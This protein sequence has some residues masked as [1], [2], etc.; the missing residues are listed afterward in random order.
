MSTLLRYLNTE[1]QRNLY[2]NVDFYS[3][4][5]YK[6]MGFPTDMFPVLFSIARTAGWLAHWREQ[7]M[8]KTRTFRPAEVYVGSGIREY[9][10]IHKRN[11]ANVGQSTSVEVNGDASSPNNLSAA[12]VV[13][14]PPVTCRKSQPV[15]HKRKDLPFSTW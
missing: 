3:G 8:D 13:S 15:K 5:I 7:L 6:A 9:I 1:I 14:K 10:P 12:S 11:E 4:I 2:P